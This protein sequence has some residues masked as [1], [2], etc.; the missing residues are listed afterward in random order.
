MGS[1]VSSTQPSPEAFR[2]ALSDRSGSSREAQCSGLS[3]SDTSSPAPAPAQGTYPAGLSQA[4]VKHLLNKQPKKPSAKAHLGSPF[5][6]V[7]HCLI[8][9][10]GRSCQSIQSLSQSVGQPAILIGGSSFLHSSPVVLVFV[11]IL[12][13]LS[14]SLSLQACFVSLVI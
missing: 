6:R 12:L 7:S 8:Q 14:L 1:P 13:Y 5:N 9:L 4:Q 2:P 10:I 11:I 3:H